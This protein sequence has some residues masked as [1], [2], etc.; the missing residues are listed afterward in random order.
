[1]IQYDAADYVCFIEAKHGTMGSVECLQH[2]TTGRKLAKKRLKDH[3]VKEVIL[4]EAEKQRGILS[5][6]VVRMLLTIPAERALLLEY[7]PEGLDEYLKRVLLKERAKVALPV[8]MDIL[9]HV[10]QGLS[11]AHRAGVVHG[12]IK[13]ANVRFGEDGLAKLSDFG[14]ARSVRT[15][16]PLAVPGSTNWMAKDVA[17]GAA[18]S[19]ESDWFS[20]GILAYLILSG[21][22]PFYVPDK[23]CLTSPA[24]H[25]KDP[26]YVVP[27]LVDLNQDVAPGIARHIQD[28]LCG[29]PANRP[30][31]ARKLRAAFSKPLGIPELALAPD[32]GSDGES[33][34]S[35]IA[36][37]ARRSAARSVEE[38]Y[39][40]DSARA[41][42]EDVASLTSDDTILESDRIVVADCFTLEAFVQ[43][44][45]TAV[46]W[47]A[48]ES[49][50]QRA[51][52]LFGEHVG[53]L[54]V[55]GYAQIHRGDGALAKGTLRAA[56]DLARSDVSKDR[57][58]RYI[59][60][61]ESEWP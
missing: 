27:A 33:E 47:S 25:V 53:A 60:Y 31:T 41:V 14:A 55:A 42:L 59:M 48:V 6:F 37:E 51:L 18:P 1:V 13:P 32:V 3:V 23:T 16:D 24:D 46:D 10:M 52:S 61:L 5:P 58:Q 22:H 21:Q 30:N 39:D 35:R 19:V 57:I 17:Q 28:L 50:A 12:D 7:C 26:D 54:Y 40:W 11:D 38:D 4:A 9:S 36:R 20:F 45:D 44:F 2:R 15:R 49:S 8:A 34:L 43:C 56:K 29:E